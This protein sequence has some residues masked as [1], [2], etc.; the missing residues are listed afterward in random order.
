MLV[1]TTGSKRWHTL[2]SCP[3]WSQSQPAGSESHWPRACV[4]SAG[5]AHW[6][7]VGRSN[8][9]QLPACTHRLHLHL[10]LYSQVQGSSN[11]LCSPSSTCR[12]FSAPP[13]EWRD[14]PPLSGCSGAWQEESW[15]AEQEAAG[16]SAG[17]VHVHHQVPAGQGPGRLHV[18]V[19][20]AAGRRAGR[21]HVSGWPEWPLLAVKGSSVVRVPVLCIKLQ[22][23]WSR[24]V[25]QG[26]AELQ[27]TVLLPACGGDLFLLVLL[28]LGFSFSL[29]H[30][31]TNCF[32]K[33][34]SCWLDVYQVFLFLSFLETSS[35][36]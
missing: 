32:I 12:T 31:K 17:R 13:A 25:L 28:R 8:T 20:E 23:S 19:Q 27:Q 10:H 35:Q 5:R 30:E 1:W 21:V 2:Q 24:K 18:A 29:F 7:P 22:F 16:C 26:F 36:R 11:S 34:S 9:G 6:L 4:S 15:R 3:E 14:R 33:S